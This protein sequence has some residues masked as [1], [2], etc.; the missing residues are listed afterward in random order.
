MSLK[1][2]L[3]TGAETLWFRHRLANLGDYDLR[4]LA[5]LLWLEKHDHDTTDLA[6][7]PALL[8]FLTPKVEQDESTAN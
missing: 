5:S 2:G 4:V 8:D 1:P 7:L 6:G 3:L